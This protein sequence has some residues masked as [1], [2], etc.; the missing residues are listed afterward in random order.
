MLKEF[1]L[2]HFSLL[3]IVL[4]R[5]PPRNIHISEKATDRN[6][7]FKIKIKRGKDGN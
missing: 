7:K 6:K 3:F 2:Y 4:K 1:F 5:K